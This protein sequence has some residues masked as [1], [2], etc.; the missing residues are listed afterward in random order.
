VISLLYNKYSTQVDLLSYF[1]KRVSADQILLPV[2]KFPSHQT[3]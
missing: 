3:V 2:L 1:D